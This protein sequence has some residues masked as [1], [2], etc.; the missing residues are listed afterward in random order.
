MVLK[1]AVSLEACISIWTH[2]YSH[3]LTYTQK[4]DHRYRKKH[5]IQTE[6]KM[7]DEQMKG[8]YKEQNQSMFVKC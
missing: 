4:D 1:K 5:S 3:A 7:E 2:T 6:F 8:L